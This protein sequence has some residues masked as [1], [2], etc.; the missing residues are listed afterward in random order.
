MTASGAVVGISTDEPAQVLIFA[1]FR[2]L[3]GWLV[4]RALRAGV[5]VRDRDL[6]LRGYFRTRRV[7]LSDISDVTVDRADSLLPWNSLRIA[8]TDGSSRT[9]SEVSSLR[10]GRNSTVAIAVAAVRELCGLPVTD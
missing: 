3:F 10:D 2:A 7:P 1:T 9:V 8:R 4:F 5:H 6:V